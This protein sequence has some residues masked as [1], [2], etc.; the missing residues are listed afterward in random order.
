M[1]NKIIFFLASFLNYLSFNCST[2][3]G[4]F[5]RNL[6]KV[7]T[8]SAFQSRKQDISDICSDHSDLVTGRNVTIRKCFKYY[9][10]LCIF[11]FPTVIFIF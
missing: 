8:T 5:N 4:L 11:V 1:Q 2:G 7:I 3:T 10:A 9:T 6:P